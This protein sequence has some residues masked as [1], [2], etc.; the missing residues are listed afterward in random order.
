MLQVNFG[1]VGQFKIT[2]MRKITQ[3]EGSVCNSSEPGN[4]NEKPPC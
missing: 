1:A 4:G 3:P 2:S